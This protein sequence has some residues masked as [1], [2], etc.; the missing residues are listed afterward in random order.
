MLTHM[1]I[2]S[3]TVRNGQIKMFQPWKSPE[4]AID[5]FVAES[6]EN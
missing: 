3:C 2:N 4:L 5:S 1:L 6:G